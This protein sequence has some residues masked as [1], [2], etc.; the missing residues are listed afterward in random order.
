MVEQTIARHDNIFSL[1]PNRPSGCYN[2]KQ[3]GNAFLSFFSY[4][5]NHLQRLKKVEI[6]K[7]R[8]STAR[9]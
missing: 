7:G 8:G 4:R 6:R 2:F 3:K 9:N 5:I 1:R